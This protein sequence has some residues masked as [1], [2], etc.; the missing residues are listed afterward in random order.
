MRNSTQVPNL[1]ARTELNGKR[2]V[3]NISE[4]QNSKITD[5]SKFLMSHQNQLNDISIMLTNNNNS[6]Y[7]TSTGGVSKY[8][9]AE[10][11]KCKVWRRI[12]QECRNLGNRVNT[13]DLASV[14]NFLGEAS[15][16]EAIQKM[17]P[18]LSRMLV[19]FRDSLKS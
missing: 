6:V 11:N 18:E 17:T 9:P 4:I 7:Q 19:S 14:L 15:Q 12:N 5:D 10:C 8:L 16:L 2:L 1:F 3:H 13:K